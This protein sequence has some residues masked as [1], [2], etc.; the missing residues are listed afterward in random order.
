MIS[1]ELENY[2]HTYYNCDFDPSWNP[3]EFQFRDLPTVFPPFL[4]DNP[5]FPSYTIIEM[6]ALHRIFDLCATPEQ[7]P[8]YRLAPSRYGANLEGLGRDSTTKI[9]VAGNARD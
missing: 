3:F 9:L 4:L 6:L 1:V 2:Y 5:R 8:S 7:L